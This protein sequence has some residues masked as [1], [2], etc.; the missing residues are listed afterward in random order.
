MIKK[1]ILLQISFVLLCYNFVACKA[2]IQ[3]NDEKKEKINTDS[4][5]IDFKKYEINVVP[6]EIT[7]W[8]TRNNIQK[9]ITT[10][11]QRLTTIRTTPEGVMEMKK[12]MFEDAIINQ[13][14]PYWY[15][16]EWS[17]SGHTTTPN[18]GQIACSY[19]T[20]TVLEHI[21]VKL[22][23]FSLSQQSPINEAMTL[24]IDNK[25]LVRFHGGNIKDILE[26]M[27]EKLENG[28]Y[29][30][31]LSENHV[32][33][34]LRQKKQLFFIHSSYQ[35]PNGVTIEM[36]DKS[37]VF[38]SFNTFFV[39]PLSNNSVFLDNWWNGTFIK[40]HKGN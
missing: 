14:I 10:L 40:T 6:A 32:G 16:T 33:F 12:K 25:S 15:G 8:T 27:N 29:F 23:R 3:N 28:L 26:N 18:N 39:V 5:I 13:I 30:V 22:D 1:I 34:L 9:E 35:T 11:R 21:G 37:N 38:R 17:F 4:T 24:D 31:G 7:Y 36:A 20:S 2:Q 19:F